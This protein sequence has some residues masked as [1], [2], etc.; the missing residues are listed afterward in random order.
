MRTSGW[1]ALLLVPLAIGC[2]GE[3]P[4]DGSGGGG[5][6]GG[7]LA[8]PGC[9]AKAPPTRFISCVVSFDPGPGAGFGQ[10]RFPELVYGPP[11]A[12]A[13]GG[14]STDVLS[15]G[16]GGSIVVGFGGNAIVDGPGVDFLVFENPFLY[17]SK[18]ALVPFAEIGEVSASED[19]ITWATFPCQ[20]EGPPYTGC[21]GWNPVHSN[22]TNGISPFDPATAG[23]DPF[24]LADVGLASARFLRI[25]DVS[26][27]GG[28]PNAGFDLDAA[29][30][31]HAM[32]P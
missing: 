29:A 27:Y 31:V 32:L 19:G 1:L 20:Q 12:D 4:G 17:E 25:R 14:G 30:V 5:S 13:H 2:G 16:R 3:P 21:A 10:D 9:D 6:G 28:P 15:L 18:G 7:A 23:G 22:P 11:Q 26:G 24:D 8:I